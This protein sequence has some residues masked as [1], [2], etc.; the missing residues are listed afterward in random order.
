MLNC[1]HHHH[2]LLLLIADYDTGTF[3]SPT[4]GHHFLSANRLCLRQ[5]NLAGVYLVS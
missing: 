5:A 1:H 3:E 2:L 4:V